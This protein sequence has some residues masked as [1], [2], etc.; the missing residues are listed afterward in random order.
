M[1]NQFAGESRL[2]PV[3]IN[4]SNTFILKEDL[5][6]DEI[7]WLSGLCFLSGADNAPEGVKL[8][9]G[10]AEKILHVLGLKHS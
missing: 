7:I 2:T 8:F 10:G 9:V 5:S 6:G 4:F 1:G 3:F